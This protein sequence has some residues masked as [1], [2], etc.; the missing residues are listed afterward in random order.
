MPL[1]P[2]TRLGPYE[3]QS[4]LG[5]GG[6][7]EVYRATDTNLGRQVAIKVLPEAFAQDADRLARFEREA[8]TLAALNHPNIA[9]I[10]GLERSATT[11]ALVME[12]VEGETLADRIARG[13]IAIDEALPIAKQI[14]E[15][16]DAAHE[17]E[18]IH[19]D[20]KPANIKV[21]D[22]GTVKVL[23]FGL[24][25][26]GE[27]V[28]SGAQ[29]L[30]GLSLS[31]TI[32]SPALMTGAG[33]LLGTA[34]YM[35]PEQAKG[36]AADKRSDI[37]AFG[38]VLFEMLSGRR[39]FDG[40]SVAET[41]GA[42]IHKEPEWSAL[43][44]NVASSVT[45]VLRRCLAKQPKQRARDIGDVL[46][47]LS[48][49]DRV[50]SVASPAPPRR[51]VAAVM[52]SVVGTAVIAAAIAALIYGRFAQQPQSD[53]VTFKVTAAEMNVPPGLRFTVPHV[54]P[55]GRYVAFLVTGTSG[56]IPPGIWM[57]SL[58][59]T[60]AHPLPGT[61]DANS[62]FWSPD[63]RFIGFAAA[64]GGG[65]NAGRLKKTDVSG[66]SPTTLCDL[67]G[68]FRGGTWNSRGDILFSVSNLGLWKVSD[69]GG[70]P[71]RVGT[72]NRALRPSFLPDGEHF[73]YTTAVG[74]A[75]EGL[76]VGALS[77]PPSDKSGP[78]LVPD[79]AGAQYVQGVDG[80]GWLLFV[81]DN[82]LVRQPFDAAHMALDGTPTVIAEDVPASTNT[83]PAFSASAT[84]VLAFLNL[85]SLV[86]QSKLEWFDRRGQVAEQ[87]GPPGRYGDVRLS[88]DNRIL[89]VDALGAQSQVRHV[90]TVDIRRSTFTLLNPG[91]D[92]ET[93]NAVSP[94]GRIA[95]T[96]T[97]GDL[98]VKRAN[99]VGDA[100]LLAKSSTTKHPNDW[101]RDGRFIVYDDHHPTQKQDLY[102]LPVAADKKPIPFVATPADETEA[103]FSPDG[104]W[105]A[106][107]SDESGRRD[108][109]VRDFVPTRVPATGTV[110]VV[111]STA[112]G[113]K[114]RWNPNGKELFYL[115]LDGTMMAVPVMATGTTFEAGT[116]TPLFKTRT[117][118]FFPYDA[119]ADGRFL[120]NTASDDA[121]TQATIT[122]MV[123][124]P[125]RSNK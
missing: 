63:S 123:N 26:L 89:A 34:A 21:R 62:L 112:G 11:P 57:R 36:K 115:A 106:Y 25:K 121:A 99:G 94:D 78:R 72:D 107:S 100:E 13:P 93:G 80:M 42:V 6:M 39:A 5:A 110:K 47:D 105:I 14:A 116:P 55:D 50:D 1:G 114:P 67:P 83:S 73:L 18:I 82:K 69:A 60:D 46:L 3:I 45:R 29:S 35:S 33:L 27:A 96:S 54:S 38:C 109:Y 124:W 24:A 76:Y 30:A 9:Q 37:W 95:Y 98:Y 74:F 71:A 90:W 102:V 2:G 111:I 58:N 17:Q 53:P 125:S 59:A 91:S 70:T 12:L 104:R 66:G 118:G 79:S 85:S 101:S 48:S 20:L 56:R 64:G 8:K 84:G 119:A 61:D 92:G 43:P 81:R 44:P 49:A 68:Q 65:Y 75:R 16:L 41:L 87:V 86:D 88:Q 28:A 7:G 23:D 51:L 113:L 19:R 117:T 22:D 122:V 31:P 97:S 120:I 52:I 4:A 15:A 10:Y 40:E 108:V 77:D 103:A 32:T